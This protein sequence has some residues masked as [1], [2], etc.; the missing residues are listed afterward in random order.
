M[1]RSPC[2]TRSPPNSSI[3]QG[4]FIRGFIVLVPFLQEGRPCSLNSCLSN[5]FL[6][7]RHRLCAVPGRLAPVYEPTLAEL[8]KRTARAGK[9]ETGE[10]S[11][12][13]SYRLFCETARPAR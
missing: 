2:M 6:L 5:S 11:G 13:V 3:R 1:I 8:L 7:A 12:G 4:R 9:T 10:E